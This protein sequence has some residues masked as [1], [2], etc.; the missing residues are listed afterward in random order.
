MVARPGIHFKKKKKSQDF[1]AQLS[2]M[3]CYYTLFLG[4]Y[5]LGEE[6]KEHHPHL[7]HLRAGTEQ[8]ITPKSSRKNG[9]P[10]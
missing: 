6:M 7:R 2:I 4:K 1:D 8:K 9:Y 5:D 10:N 3:F